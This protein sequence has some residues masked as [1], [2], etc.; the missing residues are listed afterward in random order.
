V[1]VL[2]MRCDPIDIFVVGV[3]LIWLVVLSHWHCRGVKATPV[4][5]KPPRAKRDPKPFAGFIHKPDCPLCEPEAELQPSA[6][7][8][9]AP[10][11]R[12]LFT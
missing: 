12:M 6:S 8:P 5:T 4:V 1:E 7:V 3:A 9:N 10:P 11:P 2:I